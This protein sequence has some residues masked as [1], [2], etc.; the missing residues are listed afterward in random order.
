MQKRI[1]SILL[2]LV[3]VITLLTGC[4][5]TQNPQDNIPSETQSDEKENSQTQEDSVKP[6]ESEEPSHSQDSTQTEAPSETEKPEPSESEKPEPS[7]SQKPEPSESEK[8]KPSESEKPK[9]S[10]SEKPE[11]SESEKPEPSESEKPKPSESEKPEPSES[12]KPEPSESEKPEPSESEKPKPSESQTPEPSEPEPSEPEPS[13]PEPDGD[14]MQYVEIKAPSLPNTDGLYTSQEIVN[15]II[16]TGMSDFEKVFAIHNWLTFNIDYDHSYKNYYAAET[17][18]DRKGVCQGY[19]YAFR[20]MCTLVGIE[21]TIV[22]GTGI[23]ADGSSESHAWNQVLLG[24]NWYNVDVTWDD[25]SNGPSKDPNDHSGNRYDYFLVS[26]ASLYRDHV[27]SDIVE[28]N[29]IHNCA[30][31]YSRKD[32]LKKAV[33]TGWHGDVAFASNKDELEAAVL[34]YMKGDRDGFWL[35]Y[36][37]T[38]LTDANWKAVI[39]NQLQKV[40]YPARMAKFYPLKDGIVKIW[41]E[42]TPVSKWNELALVTN[43]TE[44][45]EFVNA[46]GDAGI[47]TFSLRYEASSGTP[48][49]VGGR[50]GFS[51]TYVPYNDGKSLILT[52]TIK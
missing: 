7:E 5:G 50:Y 34:K 37:D 47:K 15:V 51:Y 23:A 45:M 13:E 2:C 20:E 1:S 4:N 36:Y 11:P 52:I 26:N 42:I 9:P 27:A 18:R 43:G 12:Q 21:T 33:E 25:P 35:W 17:L 24:G 3:M 22:G 19:A 44:F 6:T 46:K 41:I 29:E 14:K 32:I 49:I 8:P 39:D 48:E 31:D 16:K 30:N 10:E 38:S 40:S 28:G